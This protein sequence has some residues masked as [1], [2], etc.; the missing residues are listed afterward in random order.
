MPDL[1]REQVCARLVGVYSLKY[2]GKVANVWYDSKYRGYRIQIP[3]RPDEIL[4]SPYARALVASV[5]V[6]GSLGYTVRWEIDADHDI[7]SDPQAAAAHAWRMMRNPD[8]T[9]NVFTVIDK[10]TGD[11]FQVDLEDLDAEVPTD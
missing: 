9:A 7:A 6:P 3:S 5:Y 4:K 8:S 11:E 2:P 10:A 1:D